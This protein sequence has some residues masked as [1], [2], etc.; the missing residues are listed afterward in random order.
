MDKSQL[1]SG[2]D[3]FSPTVV[4]RLTEH[5]AD[6]LKN[7][8]AS[9]RQSIGSL[10]KEH[11]IV[12]EEQIAFAL[13]KQKVTGERLGELLE[14]LGFVSGYDVARMLADQEALDFVDVLQI[15]PQEEALQLFN[16]KLC[17][18]EHF[19]PVRRD[20]GELEVVSASTNME[21]LR[22]LVMARSG[23]RPRFLQ[24]QRADIHQVI[25]QYYHFL[26]HPLEALLERE[27][28]KAA[29]DTDMVR[30]LDTLLDHLLHLAIKY[31]ATDIHI[32]P[33]E[34][35]IHISFRIDGV[36]R[37]MICMDPRLK[38]LVS[39]IKMKSGIDIA[40]QRLP[41][42][43]SFTEMIL[44]NA[45]DLRVSTVVGLH[46]ESAVMRILQRNNGVK[47]F[48]ELGFTDVDMASLNRLF[49]QPSG[50]ILLTGPTGS[51]KTTS[52]YA[53]LRSMNLMEKNVLTVENPVEYQ[54]PI[55]T[56][57][58]V[59][60]RSGYSFD[61]AITHFLRHDPDVMLIGEI[62]NA[63]TAN[64]AVTAAETGH[65]V[66][67]T[68]HVNSAYGVIP[69][70]I[71]LGVSPHLLADSLIG[72]INQ[73]LVRTICLGCK[74]PYDASDEDRSYLCDESVQTLYKGEGCDACRGTGHVGRTPVY[75]A[76]RMSKGMPEL[77]VQGKDRSAFEAL[78]AN[79]GFTPI[80]DMAA[81]KVV[82]GEV[83]VA[84]L[85]RVL[86]DDVNRI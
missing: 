21:H 7:M 16:M 14:R 59:N 47:G 80:F 26:E 41:Q 29:K 15:V 84:E 25:R 81:A 28:E 11:G 55:A 76:I 40:E 57:T 5:E 52:L 1:M 79:S 70:L 32:Q 37:P 13:Q 60:T 66:L 86:G 17:L 65:L 51:G 74:Q 71:S 18:V 77:I 68:L 69:R 2:D 75:E 3:T 22:Q 35:S 42:D 36:L 53:G 73:R 19:L 82:K 50:M 49:S 85:M 30:S 45:Y 38:R 23:L 33:E 72:I 44:E 56:Q 20:G 39:T 9:K 61:Y 6:R 63:E 67:S 24:G 64:T 27:V 34:R 43:G 31:R 48:S 83:S 46:G 78:A 4:S 12:S 58:E 8:A 10:L 54:I 62:R